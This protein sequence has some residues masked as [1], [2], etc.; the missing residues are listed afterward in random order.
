V[1]VH[2]TQYLRYIHS[3]T[4][5]QKIQTELNKSMQSVFG[6][7]GLPSTLQA[8]LGI[9]PLML[10]QMKQLACS[11][12]RLTNSDKNS[13]PGQI[14][15]FKT[16]NLRHLQQS[17][18]ENRII[19]GCQTVFSEWSPSEPLPQPKYL[20]RVLITNREKSFG[21]SLQV[22]L[23]NIWRIQLRPQPPPTEPTWHTSYIDIAGSDIDR[24]DLFKPG[25]YLLA[26]NQ[27]QMPVSNPYPR[28]KRNSNPPS[29]QK[30][31]Q[32]QI[33]SF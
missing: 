9:P 5:L 11:H 3:H 20:E 18:L 4:Q 8:D 6:C 21:R 12:F 30:T 26:D 33:S 27:P 32:R 1:L 24:P 19:R 13:I 16:H 7:V 15:A 23:S 14:F 29:P 10:Y 22:P 25:P 28:Y 31:H 2:A 17:D